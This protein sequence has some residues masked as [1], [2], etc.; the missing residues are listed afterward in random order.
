MLSIVNK[1]LHNIDLYLPK[2][3]INVTAGVDG[4]GNGKARIE[5][6]SAPHSPRRQPRM[7]D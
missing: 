5:A 3:K 7:S 2:I 4:A 1:Q 6:H